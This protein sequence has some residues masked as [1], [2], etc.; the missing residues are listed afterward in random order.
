[1]SLRPMKFRMAFGFGEQ[2]VQLKC[3]SGEGYSPCLRLPSKY[4]LGVGDGQQRMNCGRDFPMYS[5][6][7]WPCILPY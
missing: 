7:L 6:S 3:L 5:T 2:S 4:G 1:M